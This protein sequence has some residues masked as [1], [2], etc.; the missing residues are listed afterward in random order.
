MK[1]QSYSKIV[2]SHFRNGLIYLLTSDNTIEI[3]MIMSQ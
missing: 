3:Y 2:D 1:R